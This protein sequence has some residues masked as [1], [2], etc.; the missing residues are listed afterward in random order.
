MQSNESLVQQAQ[1]GSEAERREAFGELIDRFQRA[2]RAWAY[3]VLGDAQL[4]QDAA[5]DAFI[6]AYEKLDQ[7]REPAAFPAWLKR[8]VLTHCYRMTRRKSPA[9]SPV[10]DEMPVMGDDPAANA[11][12]LDERERVREAV[13]ALPD[14]ERSVTELFYLYGYSLD[15]IARGLELPVTTVK[16]RLQYAR[17]RIRETMPRA[18]LSIYG[19]GFEPEMPFGLLDVYPH[20]WFYIDELV[21]EVYP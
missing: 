17:E 13:R 7:L 5:Q 16:K 19:A 21:E 15:E 8:I 14:R 10:D 11:E 12:A 18:M 9:F 4:V 3:S 1:S 20:M 2:A 6:T